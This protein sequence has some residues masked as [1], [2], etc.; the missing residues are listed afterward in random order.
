MRNLD[1]LISVVIHHIDV[2]RENGKLNSY[3]YS[4]FLSCS[5]AYLVS[6]R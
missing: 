5:T 2:D 6:G 1:F 3:R 4:S